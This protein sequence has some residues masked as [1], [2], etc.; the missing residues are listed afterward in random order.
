M[1]VKSNKG[2]KRSEEKEEKM[3]RNREKEGRR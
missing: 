2:E 1:F 3:N